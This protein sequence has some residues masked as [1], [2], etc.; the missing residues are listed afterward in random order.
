MDY[1]LSIPDIYN[2]DKRDISNKKFFIKILNLTL[3]PNIYYDLSDL[4]EILKKSKYY[5]DID[6]DNIYAFYFKTHTNK[7]EFLINNHPINIYNNLL[8]FNM[9]NH[10]TNNIYDIYNTSDTQQHIEIY[11]IYRN[12]YYMELVSVRP[13]IYNKNSKYHNDNYDNYENL[14]YSDIDMMNKDTTRWY[15]YY[16]QYNDAMQTYDIMINFYVKT[17]NNNLDELVRFESNDII[18]YFKYNYKSKISNMRYIY[19]YNLV[20]LEKRNTDIEYSCKLNNYYLD[21]ISNVIEY[22]ENID[23]IYGDIYRLLTLNKNR[24]DRYFLDF[25]T[26][27]IK[28]DIDEIYFYKISYDV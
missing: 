3:T 27:M 8:F 26:Y 6:D 9:K 21:N 20:K 1:N 17:K 19:K 23:G 16:A 7:I 13:V 18:F 10:R 25:K 14:F 2:F 12:N 28:N 5:D 11:I 24:C 15:K 22:L 4:T